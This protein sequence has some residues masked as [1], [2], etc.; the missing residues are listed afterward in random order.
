MS[1]SQ[2]G[3][4]RARNDGKTVAPTRKSKR[5]AAQSDEVRRENYFYSRNA[6]A[7][8]EYSTTNGRFIY[9]QYEFEHQFNIIDT[10]FGT[11][12]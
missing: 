1:A 12:M 3:K 11:Q 2:R 4:K 5:I 8:E 6:Y 7:I 9:A 10:H